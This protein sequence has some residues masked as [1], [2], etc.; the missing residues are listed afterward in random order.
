M[1]AVGV[2]SVHKQRRSQTAM[3]ASKGG[4]YKTNFRRGVIWSMK[5]PECS[6]LGLRGR[7]TESTDLKVGRYKKAAHGRVVR[8]VSIP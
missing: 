5:E 3:P 6:G 7:E 2:W 1:V 4:R 8:G